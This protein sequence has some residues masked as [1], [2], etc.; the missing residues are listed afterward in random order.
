[1]SAVIELVPQDTAVYTNARKLID[2]GHIEKADKMLNMHLMRNPDDALALSFMVEILKK[3]DRFPAAYQLAKRITELRPDRAEAWCSLGGAAQGLWRLDEAIDCYRKA[4]QRASTRQQKAL[5]ASNIASS[6]LD[7]GS[8]VG[9]EEFCRT[10]LRLDSKDT[11]VRHNLGLSL[12]GQRKWKEAWPFYSASVGS[13]QRNNVKYKDPAEP[14][15]DGTKDQTIVVY[16]EQGVGDEICAASMLPDVI[17]DSKKVIIDCDHRLKRLFQR[18]FPEATVHGTRWVPGN[19]KDEAATIDASIAGFEVGKFYRNDDKDFPGTPYLVP[20]PDRLAMWK[21]LWATKKKPVIGIAW[22]GGIWQNAAMYRELPLKEWQPIFDSIG[23]HFVSLQYKDA[24]KDIAG[25][26]VVQYPYATLTPDY[27]DT[28]ALV[29]SCDLVIGMQTS[30][31]HTAGALGVP[32]WTM[33][34]K[35]SQWRY[36]E[37]YT[38][39][40]WYKSMKLYRQKESWAPVVRKIAE[41]LKAWAR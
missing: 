6:M 29:A 18:S 10:A 30:V 5:Y 25:T 40:P 20:C 38:D 37:E 4:D 24:E 21:A 11:S 7:G 8:F 3:A 33:I 17:R 34:P 19:W 35:Q 15:W 41:D 13:K 12:L 39:V 22:T 1:V 27:D 2:E 36:G 14:T 32:V 31:C 23:A 26:P 9:S 28:A 16:G